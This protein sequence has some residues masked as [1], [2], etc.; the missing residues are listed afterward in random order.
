MPHPL[1]PAALVLA[2]ALALTGCGA[3]VTPEADEKDS[4]AQADRHYPVTVENCGE[5]KR[6]DKAP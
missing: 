1:R 6:Y 5:K 4:S 2:A 3:D